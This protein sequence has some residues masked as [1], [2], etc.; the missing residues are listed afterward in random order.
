MANFEQKLMNEFYMRQTAFF[1]VECE[2]P[3][4]G[5]LDCIKEGN[6][7]AECKEKL[8]SLGSC[9]SANTPSTGYNFTKQDIEVTR[10]RCEKE[11]EMCD[12]YINRFWRKRIQTRPE[13]DLTHEFR[14]MFS[15]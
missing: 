8:E 3:L 5:A 13:N 2:T 12:E 10:A 6:E 15:S 9:V 11:P 1:S 7:S 4:R 14:S